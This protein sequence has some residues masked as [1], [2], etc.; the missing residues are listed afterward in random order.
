VKALVEAA[1]GDHQVRPL[2][3]LH[4]GDQPVILSEAKDHCI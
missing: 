3:F 2:E 1:A 4:F